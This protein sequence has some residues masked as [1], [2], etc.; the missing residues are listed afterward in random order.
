MQPGGNV[1]YHPRRSRNLPRLES[2]GADA[3]WVEV[4][5][6]VCLANMRCKWT[7]SLSLKATIGEIIPQSEGI[8]VSLRLHMNGTP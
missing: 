7:R 1:F 6:D 3:G 4:G 8:I 5:P 2:Q